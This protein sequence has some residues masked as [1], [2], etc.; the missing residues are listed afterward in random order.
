MEQT[1]LIM[2]GDET[3]RIH[4]NNIF[5]FLVR[6][7]NKII[8]NLFHILINNKISKRTIS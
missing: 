5:V 3:L 1:Y 8:K 7:T 2:K 4:E 6:R